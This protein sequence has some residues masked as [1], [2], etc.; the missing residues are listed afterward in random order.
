MHHKFFQVF[1]HFL[2][3]VHTNR[4]CKYSL[5]IQVDTISLIPNTFKNFDQISTRQTP[6][7]FARRSLESF[8]R[9]SNHGGGPQLTL[10]LNYLN[11][12]SNLLVVPKVTINDA[13][14]AAPT[15]SLTYTF[16]RKTRPCYCLLV[17]KLVCVTNIQGF[18]AAGKLC[19]ISPLPE[20]TTTTMAPK[21]CTMLGHPKLRRR[22][23]V[24]LLTVTEQTLPPN[25]PPVA[26]VGNVSRAARF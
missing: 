1:R 2:A 24:R 17:S 19:L 8:T 4:L 16:E 15:P 12:L 22:R 13:A 25:W 3:A 6:L 20:T 5:F 10:P 9:S 21:L 26:T 14:V 23:C 18:R 11:K 7:E